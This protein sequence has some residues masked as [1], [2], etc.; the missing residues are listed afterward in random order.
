MPG[1]VFHVNGAARR[2]EAD[3]ATPLVYVL[4]NDLGLVAT[5]LGCGEGECGSCTVLVDGRPEQ[6]CQTPLEAVAGKHVETVESLASEEGHHP[7]LAS[8]IAEQAGQCGYCLAGILM[9]AKALL[10]GG[11][12]PG[13]AEI[14]AALDGHLCRCGAHSRIVRA[15]EK[16]ARAGG[17]PS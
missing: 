3:P 12:V 8:L 2:L 4:R 17:S 7:L 15:I 11:R 5:R 6:A 14:A 16:A 10:E 9:R 13:R 1:T